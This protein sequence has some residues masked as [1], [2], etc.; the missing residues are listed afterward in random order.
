MIFTE[1]S[2]W[3]FFQN[4]PN[5]LP[6]VNI[7]I[8]VEDDAGN[9]KTVTSISDMLGNKKGRTT[10]IK[11]SDFVFKNLKD[12]ANYMIDENEGIKLTSENFGDFDVGVKFKEDYD[13]K[14]SVIDVENN[15]VA[16]EEKGTSR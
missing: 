1:R 5:S 9:Q 2:K 7:K 4:D 6:L 13:M 14:T 12:Q 11:E 16:S 3:R 15:C 10:T 8:T